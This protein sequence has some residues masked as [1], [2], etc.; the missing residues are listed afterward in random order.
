MK[1]SL[2][3]LVSLIV[4]VA[5]RPADDAATVTANGTTSAAEPSPAQQP[6]QTGPSNSTTVPGSNSTQ[7]LPGGE[8]VIDIYDVEVVPDFWD[9]WFA[10]FIGI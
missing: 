10:Y 7:D 8:Y 3:V 4:I 5:S 1:Y 6:A 9:G 2:I